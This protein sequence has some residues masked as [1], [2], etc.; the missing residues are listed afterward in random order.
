MLASFPHPAFNFAP[1][2]SRNQIAAVADSPTQANAVL[3]GLSPDDHARLL[4]H[5]TPCLFHCSQVLYNSGDEVQ[6][7]Y[8]LKS[9]IVSLI[10]TSQTGIDVEIG[11]VGREGLLGASE[12]LANFPSLTRAVVQV[13]GSGWRVSAATLRDLGALQP[14]L[15]QSL[16]RAVQALNQQTAQSALCN[17]LHAVDQRLARWILMCQDRIQ[18]EELELTHEALGRMLGTRRV[19]VT[20]AAGTLRE[21]GLIDYGRGVI[22]I[23]DRPGLEARSCECYCAIRQSYTAL[24]GQKR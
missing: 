16:W 14:R 17:R 3:A 21:A 13:V 23:L 22:Q 7:I 2:P 15:T 8:F 4:P 11:L 18:S 24:S 5:L 6:N 9:G 1:A 19:G 12:A 20:V 10:L